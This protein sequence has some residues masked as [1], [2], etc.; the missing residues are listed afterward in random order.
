MDN[1]R[2]VH[3]LEQAARL[4]GPPSQTNGAASWST[5][6]P[7]LISPFEEGLATHPDLQELWGKV[8]VVP[9]GSET[10]SPS[11]AA[12]Y[13]VD[14]A[15][16]GL[17]PAD[18]VNSLLAITRTN[19]VIVTNVRVVGDVTVS[20]IIDLGR[21]ARLLPEACL[22]ATDQ[23]LFAFGMGRQDGSLPNGTVDRVALAI[24]AVIQPFVSRPPPLP[25]GHPALVDVDTATTKMIE[26]SFK[27]AENALILVA[28]A[29]PIFGAGYSFISAPGW[30]SSAGSG[31]W[32]SWP[33]SRPPTSV[34]ISSV[35]DLRANF[36]RLR[37]LHPT[38]ALAIRRLHRLRTRNDEVEKAIDLG[39]CLE[40]LLMYGD[41]SEN[42]EITNKIAHRG[43][44][45]LGKNVDERKAV[46]STIKAIYALRSKAVHKGRMP[47]LKNMD[48]LNKRAATFRD[49]EALIVRLI[50]RL[51]GGWPNWADLTLGEQ[52]SAK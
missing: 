12:I 36:E 21:G 30:P 27:A 23:R 5:I 38:I 32:G 6:N 25:S 51:A 29:A 13:L 9:G 2:L 22:P 47:D 43:A 14:K 18:I 52:P 16:S 37:D 49:S 40:M 7:R 8:A 1:D 44:W 10:L 17:P 33:V 31:A 39:G 48:A 35:D 42:T 28:D 26:E 20:E 4:V 15:K 50:Q 34:S 45:L 19:E 24:D 46:L 3:L 41:E 11:S